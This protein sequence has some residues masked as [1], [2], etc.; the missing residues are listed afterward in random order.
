ML[1]PSGMLGVA[2]VPGGYRPSMSRPLPAPPPARYP[3]GA[4]T[5][6]AATA[7]RRAVGLAR[8]AVRGVSLLALATTCATGLAW[9]A[10]IGRRPPVDANDWAARAVVLAIALAPPAVLGLFLLGLRELAELPRRV[11][12]LPPELRSHAAELRARSARPGRVGVIGA[13]VRLARLLF[14][15]RDTLSPYAVISAVLRPALL[16]SA[17]VAAIVASIEIPIALVAT[18]VLLAS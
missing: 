18:L 11:R 12:E 10:W 14:E 4:R 2:T 1:S 5:D 7:L 13:V 3:G 6:R 15:A 9:V 17:I 16:V 8:G